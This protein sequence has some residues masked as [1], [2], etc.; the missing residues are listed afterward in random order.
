MAWQPPSAMAGNGGM[1]GGGVDISGSV[2]PQGTEYTLQ[3]NWWLKS[4][5]FLQFEY[6]RCIP[7]CRAIWIN[8]FAFFI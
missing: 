6:K 8:S 5:V 1:G 2:G 4:I 3:G 7:D